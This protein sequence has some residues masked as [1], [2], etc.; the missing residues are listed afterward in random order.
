[1]RKLL[2]SMSVLLLLQT[3]CKES[4]DTSARYVYTESTIVTYLERH[5]DVYS[6]YIALLKKVPIS[7]ISNSTVYQ[8][9]TARGNFTVFAPTND[10]VHAYLD[11]L[12]ADGLIGE[13][14]WDAFKVFPDSTKLDSIRGV[15]V[16]N[17][18]ID[19]GDLESQRFDISLFPTTNNG[20]F[21]LANLNDNKLTIFWPE[22][23]VDEYYVNGTCKIDERNRDIRLLNGVMYQ[24]HSVIAPKETT[25]ATFFLNILERQ[26]EGLLVFARAIQACG[27]MDTLKAVRD[28]VYEE[29]RLRNPDHFI[30]EDFYPDKFT[31]QQ[32]KAGDDAEMPEHRKY[33]FTFFPETDEY[34]R[35]QGLDPTDPDLL[36]KLTQWILDNHQY[37]ESDNLRADDNYTSQDNL[38]NYWLTYHIMPFRVAANKLV[39]HENEPG[40]SRSN[41]YRYT[42]PVYEYYT[43]FG[44]RRL[45]KFYE[46]AISEGVRLNRFPVINNGR[47]DDGKEA[48]CDPD[49]E[50]PLVQT[51]HELTVVNDVV[52][53]AIYP[54]DRPLAYSDKVR[55]QLARE[56]IRF[57]GM[58]L[59]PEAI[60]NDVRRCDSNEPKHQFVYMAPNSV[61]KYYE[62]FS[63]NDDATFV[64]FNGYRYGWNLFRNDEMKCIGRYDLMFTLPP[65]PR[66]GTYEVRYMLLATGARGIVQVYFG[67]NPD[68][69]PVA[70]IPIDIRKPLN[71]YFTF[72]V[73][74]TSDNDYNAEMDKFLRNNGRLRGPACYSGDGYKNAYLDQRIQRFIIARQTMDPNETYYIRFKNVLDKQMNEFHMDF[75]ELC[76]K[77][78]YDNPETPEDIW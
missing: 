1:M 22:K 19:G 71:Q 44:R 30:F 3:G 58:A 67:S 50:G 42:I 4:I 45:I 11:S 9:L 26:E 2:F 35:S 23:S 77:E 48:Y 63:A 40:Y 68:N 27:L 74:P 73:T 61:Y 15:V 46:S 66:R 8:L 36:E 65:V 32:A 62:N 76:P 37:S 59:F 78:V 54:I 28:E 29:R 33:G 75:L 7:R 18:I 53:A 55:D 52:N 21:P 72:D 10:A 56:R 14:T 6:E 12:V 39:Y 38:L 47:S 25:A 69:L 34:W 41:P 51:D 64:Y 49:K 24:I 70:G 57:D 31:D 20:E 16:K 43:T 17:S 13:P 5:S 60:T